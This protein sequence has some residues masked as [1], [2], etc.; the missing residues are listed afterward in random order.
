MGSVVA[1]VY[2][3]RCLCCHYVLIK[4]CLNFAMCDFHYV[5]EPLCLYSTMFMAHCF[6]IPP[7]TYSTLFM[8]HPGNVSPHLCSLVYLVH[9]VYNYSTMSML[10]HVRNHVSEGACS[11]SLCLSLSASCFYR[12]KIERKQRK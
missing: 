5:Y 12:E 3:P 9:R 8:P 10:H 1:Y 2:V 11:L 6:Y 4:S 7:C